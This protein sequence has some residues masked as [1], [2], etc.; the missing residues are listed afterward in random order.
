MY[1]IKFPVIFFIFWMYVSSDILAENVITLLMLNISDIF[2]VWLY[3]VIT[4]SFQHIYLFIYLF[5]FFCNDTYVIRATFNSQ[6][7][8]IISL[9]H[10]FVISCCGM[11]MK[12]SDWSKNHEH[13]LKKKT[14]SWTFVFTFLVGHLRTVLLYNGPL[15]CSWKTF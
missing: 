8:A 15:P 12:G 7:Q 13:S 1:L 14:F 3:S 9:H 10:V 4:L 5:A 2:V 6:F 11:R